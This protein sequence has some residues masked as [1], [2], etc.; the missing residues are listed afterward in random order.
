MNLHCLDSRQYKSSNQSR[1]L[2]EEVISQS[3]G[4][5]TQRDLST[6]EL[7]RRIQGPLMNLER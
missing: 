1:G 2:K 7:Q 4:S 5:F 3:M 6:I